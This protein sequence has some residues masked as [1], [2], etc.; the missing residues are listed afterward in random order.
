MNSIKLLV[1]QILLLFSITAYSQTACYISPVPN[2][3]L[4]NEKT[5]III[6]YNTAINPQ[7]ISFSVK[8]SVSGYHTGVIKAVENNTKLL[9]I[10]YAQFAIG[11][12][13]SVMVSKDSLSFTFYIRTSVLGLEKIKVTDVPL[14]NYRTTSKPVDDSLPPL[15]ISQLGTTAP[16]DIFISNFNNSGTIPSF[17]M[18][19]GNTGDAIYSRILSYRGY[20]FKKQDRVNVLSYYEES[21]HGFFCLDTNY[22]IIDTIYA[23]NGYT[24]DMHELRVMEDGSGWVLSYDNEYVNMST[25][26]PGGNPAAIVTGIIVQHVDKNN[27]V[28]F[29]WRSWDHVLITDATHE[30]LTLPTI[31]YMHTNAIEIDNDNNIMISSRHFDEITKINPKTGDI[32]WR[33]G[34]KNNQFTFINDTLQFSHQHAIRRLS[35]GNIILFDNGNYHTPSFSRAVEYNLDETNKTCTLVW[36]FDHDKSVYAFAM[37]NAQRLPNGN[38]LIGYGSATTTLTEVDSTGQILYELSLPNGQMSYRAFRY[39][40]NDN[41]TPIIPRETITATDYA[42]YQ[43]YPNPFNPVTTIKFQIPVNTY[44][45]VKIYDMT[46]R[47]V[48]MI[49]SGYYQKGSYELKWNAGDFA[50]GIYFYRLEAGVVNLT[51]KM[52]LIK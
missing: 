42:L 15:V 22:N 45:S 4:N 28:L 29:Q 16:G 21:V 14:T 34:G 27:D 26:V 1:A 36:Q 2:S 23:G 44:L 47:M 7:E 6:G 33:L 17:L 31:D 52:V 9:F 20:D 32:I 35:N 40:W 51:Q 30:N 3:S 11:D 24:T 8:G 19:L 39:V 12:T 49:A 18:I 38:T 5:N 13:V 48:D 43:N 46:G 10:P 41:V 37:G 25:I 50:S